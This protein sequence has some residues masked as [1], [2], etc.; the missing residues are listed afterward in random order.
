MLRRFN[1]VLICAACLLLLPSQ[2]LA[3]PVT[4]VSGRILD[5]QNGDPMPFVSVIFL[6][7][8]IGTMSDDNG[9]FTLENDKGFVTLSFQMLG[10]ET[11]VLPVTANKETT[12]LVIKMS[13]DVYNLQSVVVKPKRGRDAAYK[14][15][16][17][18]A[19]ELVKKVIAHKDQ[20][21]VKNAEHYSVDTYEKL[22]LALDKFEVNFDSSRFWRN[23]K[24]IEKYVDTAQFKSTPVLT[25]S[26][27]ETQAQDFYQ[28]KPRREH[29]LVK[30]KRIQG[31]E[32]ILDKEGLATNLDAM[33][34]QADIFDDN[35]E[36]MLNRFVSPL[37]SSLATNYYK[38]YISDTL[39]V[40]GKEC[41]DLTFV[42]FNSES[43]SFTGHLYVVNDSTYAVKKYSLN[44]PAH[45]NLN[46]VSHLAIEESFEQ[47]ENGLWT[48]VEKNTFARF[49]IFKKMRQVYAHQKVLYGD[50]DFQQQMPPHLAA[51]VNKETVADNAR[52]YT[53]EQW[54]AMRPQPLS[55]KESVIDSLMVEIRRVPRFNAILNTGEILLSN[56]IPTSK[57]RKAS[58]F[59]FGP[60]TNTL[61]Y[62]NQ[63]GVRI[64]VGGMTTSNLTPRNFLLG[65][66]AFGTKDLRLKYNA[67]YIHSFTPKKY[68]PYESLRNALYLSASYDAT[69]LGQTFAVLDRDHI[70]MSSFVDKPMQYVRK[71]EARYEKEW[72]SR[73]SIATSLGW[74]RN[75]AAGL[76]SYNRIGADGIGQP[77]PSFDAVEWM[78]E[79]RFAPGEPLSSN[80]MGKNSPFNLSKDAPIVSLTHRMGF[81]DNQYFYNRTDIV[82]EK[83]FWLSSFGHIDASL[84]TGIIWNRVP[85][86]KLYIP[87]ANQSF[88]L[89]PNAFNMMRPMEFVMDQYAAL[90]ATYYLKG[91]ILN[92]IPLVNK[93]KLRE[94]VSFNMLV[95]TLSQQNNPYYGTEG[96]YSL[97]PDTKLMTRVPYMEFTVGLE[98][99]FKFIRVDYVRRISYLDGLTEGQKHGIK[100]TFRFT[101]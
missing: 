36:V 48:P 87:T 56:Y 9:N 18:P 64:R 43:Y 59:D 67:T 25:V 80:R 89:S 51:S 79:L 96:L 5:A 46:F 57:D 99:I 32:D 4:K 81:F 69:V 30:A 50:Y 74:E 76:L 37:S 33:F 95:G 23:F 98:N 73:I 29:R 14:K 88:L 101:L 45:I 60:F 84:Q 70:M 19:V 61:S 34:T 53:K 24:F 97:P 42:P 22:I 20:N 16:G 7:S 10:Y 49:Y 94:V 55:S 28:Q 40:D 26:L 62:N 2:L 75:E 83:R 100:F 6:G 86:P 72:E 63:E 8:Q 68:H 17:N 13:P 31:V 52:S 38:Y 90:F 47:A 92:R 58:K 66:V 41:I 54:T 93:L 3:G 77:K 12:D 71:F 65:Y 85:F 82:A 11:Y 39:K 15:K 21:R 27:K 78:G 1:V 91:W 44:I 35:L